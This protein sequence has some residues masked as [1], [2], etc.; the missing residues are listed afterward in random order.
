MKKLHCV[1]VAVDGTLATVV[2]GPTELVQAC[3]KLQTGRPELEPCEVSCEILS[4]DGEPFLAA[5]GYRLPVDGG[6]KDLPPGTV[7]LLPGFGLPL[8]DRIPELLERHV[9]LGAW[10][11]RQHA[12]G[13]M[14]VAY[15]SGSFLLAENGLL[16]RKRATTYWLYADLFRERYP[17]IELDP[18]ALLI[19]DERVLNVGGMAC[20]LDATLTVIERFIG[21]EC[22]RLCTKLLVVESRPPSEWRYEQ[23]QH[24]VHNDPLIEKA[25]NWI[26]ANLHT[27]FTVDDLLRQVPTSRRSLGR[28]FKLETGEGIQAFIQRMRLERAKLLLETTSLPVEQIVERVGYRDASALARQFK[29][30]TKLTPNQFRRRYGLSRGTRSRSQSNGARGAGGASARQAI[31]R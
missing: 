25:V 23:R 11:K 15:C 21:S 28:R 6:L 13:S 9:A 22:A 18:D 26:R 8:T 14:I 16:K 27:R 2:F 17:G 19:E 1:A 30:Y 10:L 12:A 4:P 29:H 5:S 24:A 3:S 20:G 7:I 31:Y